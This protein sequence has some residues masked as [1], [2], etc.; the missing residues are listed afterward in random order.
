MLLRTYIPESVAVLGCS[1]GNGFDR[2]D[3]AVT[4]RVI[5]VDVNPQYVAAT[6]QR[7]EARLPG[8]QLIVGDI[9]TEAVMFE[10]VKLIYAAL[11]LEYVDPAVVLRRMPSL[12]TPDG[13][14]CIVS[15]RPSATIPDVTPTLFVSLGRLSDVM[16][17]VSPEQLGVIAADLEFDTIHE[18]IVQS[19]AGKKFQVQVFQREA[20]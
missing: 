4:R 15:Q 17:P 18:Q 14:L 3:P 1:G 2:I 11:V 10:P 6:C 16:N 12:L 19:S 13:Q 20:K 5:G 9:A 8:L 7:F